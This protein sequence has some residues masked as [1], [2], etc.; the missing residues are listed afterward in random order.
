MHIDT[1]NEAVDV[2]HVKIEK[3]PTI[4]NAK[5]IQYRPNVDCSIENLKQ[6]NK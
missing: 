6:V 3:P 1:K 2:T 5:M 4:S